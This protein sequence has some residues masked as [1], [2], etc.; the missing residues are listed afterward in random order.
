VKVK[1]ISADPKAKRIALSIKQLEAA[2]LP[3]VKH[4][5]PPPRPQKAAAPPTM[6]DKLAQLANK[7][8]AR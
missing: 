6:E 5:A 3:K 4:G 7:F 2:D 1:V 8:K